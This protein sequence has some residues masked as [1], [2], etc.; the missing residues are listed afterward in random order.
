MKIKSGKDSI[1]N[2][3]RQPKTVSFFIKKNLI[4]ILLSISIILGIILG[5]II[6]FQFK[7]EVVILFMTYPTLF[8]IF[9]VTINILLITACCVAVYNALYKSTETEPNRNTLILIV[10]ALLLLNINFV[11][12]IGMELRNVEYTLFHHFILFLNYAMA[13]YILFGGFLSEVSLKI[14]KRGK[15]IEFQTTNFIK[16][17]R[18]ARISTLSIGVVSLIIFALII[19]SSFIIITSGNLHFAGQTAGAWSGKDLV[20]VLIIYASIPIG[21]LILVKYR[22]KIFGYY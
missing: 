3:N 1:N 22:R 15:I 7:I 9:Y 6:L 16:V 20:I 12:N 11:I 2:T 17:P 10:I 5:I 19:N 18:I 14:R 4:S 21:L 8:T 13:I